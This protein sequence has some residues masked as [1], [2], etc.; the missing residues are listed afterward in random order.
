MITHASNKFLFTSWASLEKL[1]YIMGYCCNIANCSLFR[2]LLLKL[3]WRLLV[4]LLLSL[5]REL[6]LPLT[7]FYSKSMLKSTTQSF[8]VVL[9]WLGL[10]WSIIWSSSTII[11]YQLITLGDACWVICSCL[12]KGLFE[13]SFFLADPP[14]LKL[15]K[16]V[17][18]LFV[19]F[20]FLV[21]WPNDVLLKWLLW[22]KPKLGL[23]SVYL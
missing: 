17:S 13:N 6:S 9:L 7:R 18:K 8:N 3:L 19:E 23:W 4:L 1:L 14:R 10:A 5:Y 20:L 15:F 2:L 22:L 12:I 21:V 16:L 11:C